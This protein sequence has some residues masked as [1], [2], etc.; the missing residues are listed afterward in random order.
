MKR[1]WPEIELIFILLAGWKLFL[2]VIAF[3][4]PVFIPLRDGFLGP[5]PWANFDGVHYL[6]I[7]QNGYYQ[8]EQAFFPLYPLLIK[9]L[10]QI[11]IPRHIGG[12]VTSH[13]FFLGGL[14]IFYRLFQSKNSQS[15]RWSLFL[16]LLYPM[17][18]FFATVY[19]E[20][21]FF[22]LAVAATYAAKRRQWLLAG[23]FGMLAS[24]T[25][26]F[27]VF[28]LV[29]ILGEYFEKNIHRRNIGSILSISLVPLG[30]FAYMFY[31]WHSVGDP[32]AF[33]HSQP[34]F[35]AN[36]SGFGL[37]SPPQVLWRYAK[38]IFTVP[39]MTLNY[40]VALGELTTFF[41]GLWLIWKGWKQ[42]FNVNYLIYSLLILITPVLTGTLSSLPR[43][44]LSA[45]PLFFVFGNLHNTQVKLVIAFAFSLGLAICTSLFLRGYFVA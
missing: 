36:R 26:I 38:I 3:L 22:F 17:S 30:L 40:Q 5:T 13:L 1:Y 8:F 39:V 16:L 18:F 35:G 14:I 19:T 42:H 33:F 12:L 31:L 32:L 2:T 25:R 27:G 45:F 44:L 34:A 29:I 10:S 20:S 6:S 4:A 23:I 7:A 15:A 21:L 24:A 11:N 9:G 41:L 28:L 37:V 43:Y